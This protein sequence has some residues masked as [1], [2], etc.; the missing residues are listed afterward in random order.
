MYFYI[1][2]SGHT[3]PDIFNTDQPRLYYG[4]LSSHTD[5][6]G[7]DIEPVGSLRL[8]AKGNRLH[9]N[10]EG[11]RGLLS[12]S[13]E[14]GQI[15]RAAGLRF[16]LFQIA[17]PDIAIISFFDQVFDQ[18]LNPA[19]PWVGYW[20]PVRF[21]LL[22]KVASLFD[23]ELARRA[24]ETRLERN[25]NKV[26]RQLQRLCRDL[27]ARSV[28][29]QDERSRQV[30]GDA[31]EWAQNH[32]DR[33]SYGPSNKSERLAAMPNVFGL[34]AVL[35]GISTLLEQ[36][37]VSAARIVVDRQ[38]Q[39]NRAQQS[40]L[41]FYQAVKP[42]TISP[43]VRLPAMNLQ[44]LPEIPLEFL[45]GNESLGLELTDAYLWMYR[46]AREGHELPRELQKLLVEV[47]QEGSFHEISLEALEAG[48]ARY[49][50]EL[51]EPDEE[52]VA[53]AQE[54]FAQDERRRLRAAHRDA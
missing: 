44:H 54:L 12:V 31:L 32:P 6:D 26:N 17:K 33:L 34:Q 2:E 49:F 40:L 27:K 38:S 13:R 47:A 3:G 35:N 51:P 20:T 37:D 24:W 45:A 14:L 18:G 15:S 22:S 9:A 1:D 36:Q 30:V 42:A 41:E 8:N 21:V 16:D 53:R 39:F 48:W 7:L 11:N 23:E 10:E 4:L 50:E 29:L 25:S 28:R 46:R 19:V 52:G 5:L 43:G